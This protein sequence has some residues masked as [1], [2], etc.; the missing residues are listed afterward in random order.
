MSGIIR[1]T[2][3]RAL[4]RPN[5]II[6]E[7]HGS[8]GSLALAVTLPPGASTAVHF[9]GL[10]NV[11]IHPRGQAP[12]ASSCPN[13]M[14][15]ATIGERWPSL[16]AWGFRDGHLS[17]RGPLTVPASA[18]PGR[19]RHSSRNRNPPALND[20]EHVRVLPGLQ[21]GVGV[22]MQSARGKPFP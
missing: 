22:V 5:G 13:L 11:V 3:A 14:P 21:V 8:W 17:A 19:L 20:A 6:V 12:Y 1:E 10:R 15:D 9:H 16:R 2:K 4:K 7:N 18:S